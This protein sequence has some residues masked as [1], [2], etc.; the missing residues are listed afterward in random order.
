MQAV[1][2]QS[3][4]WTH[5]GGTLGNHGEDDSDE[6]TAP[7]MQPAQAENSAAAEDP[8]IDAGAAED[9]NYSGYEA[10]TGYGVAFFDGRNA[11]CELNCHLMLWNVAHLWNKGSRFAYN[12]YRH[13]GKVFVRD[14]LGKPAIVI[15]SKEGISQPK[16]VFYQ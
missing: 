13:W 11:Y 9:E 1:W 3:S 16:G 4:G 8:F 2:P 6:G 12:R 14:K 10:G 7:A 5:D 15:H